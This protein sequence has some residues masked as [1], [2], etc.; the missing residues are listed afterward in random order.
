MALYEVTV[1]ALLDRDAL[2]TGAEWASAAARVGRDRAPMLLVELADAD[3]VTGDVLAR[4]VSD[5]WR[6]ADR[7]SGV[8]EPERWIELFRDAGY[9]VDGVPALRPVRPVRLYR[10]CDAEHR[11]GMAWTD[12][13]DRA[14]WFAERPFRSSGAVWTTPAPPAALLARPGGP[15]DTDYVVDPAALGRI[16]R[17]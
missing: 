17:L 6:R 4:A 1:N 7:P 16:T 3:L 8:V 12:D 2:L 13:P 14:R 15:G 10:G 9:A 5:A 11:A